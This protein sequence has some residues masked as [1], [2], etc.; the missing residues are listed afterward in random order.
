MA[1]TRTMCITVSTTMKLAPQRCI[2]RSSAPAVIC[3]SRN[4]MLLY[5]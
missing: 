5:A 4:W 1:K 3:R 2:A